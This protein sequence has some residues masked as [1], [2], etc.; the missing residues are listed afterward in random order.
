MS[1]IAQNQPQFL[2]QR[3]SG[4]SPEGWSWPSVLLLVS[5]AAS[6]LVA[7]ML[8]LG[9]AS[10]HDMQFHLASWMDIRGQWREGILFPR[11]AE[12]ANWGFGEPRFIFY[13]PVSWILGGLLG[14]VIP[15]LAVPPVFVWLATVLAGM[16]AWRLARD[17]MPPAAA[18]AAGLLY[19]VNPYRVANAYYRSDYAELLATAIFP[20]LLC[21]AL[22]VIRR[23]WTSVPLVAV[24]FAAIWLSNA[25][26][27]VIATY[28]ICLVFSV[29]CLVAR[30]AKPLGPASVGVASGFA[31]AAFY[32]LPAASEQKWV[33]IQE[34]VASVLQPSQNFLFARGADPDFELFNMKMSYLALGMIFLAAIAS[35]FAARRRKEFPLLWSSGVALGCAA[36]FLMFPL[37]AFAWNWLPKLQYLQFPWRWCEPLGLVFALFAAIAFTGSRSSRRVWLILMAAVIVGASFLI[38]GDAWWDMEDAHCVIESIHSGNGYEGTDEY[39]PVGCDRSDLPQFGPRIARAV[40]QTGQ[41]LP[42]GKDEVQ[43]EKWT[44]E[45]IE[46]QASAQ[47]PETLVLRRLNYPAWRGSVDGRPLM[48]QGRNQ[49]GEIFFTFEPGRHHV[50]ILFARTWDRTAGGVISLLSAFGLAGFALRKRRKI[51]GGDSHG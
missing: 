17:W 32:I 30:D 25:P 36:A 34:A 21:G 22:R 51:G 16:T 10:G 28:S 14:T 43:I 49:T 18:A 33:Q 2:A 26:A 15:W 24:S 11:W 37:S 5:L 19:A 48:L 6:A 45:R 9:I 12:W 39:A 35:L 47:A 23:G 44:A 3:E 31:L 1:V 41:L 40:A 29:G 42:L 27:G 13:P 46:F 7:P 8:F 20:L 50:E 4:R 38:A